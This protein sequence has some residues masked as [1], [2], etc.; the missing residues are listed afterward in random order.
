MSRRRYQ[1]GQLIDGG[2]RWEARWREDVI[3]PLT[4]NTKRVR[5]WDVLATKKECPNKRMAQRLLDEKLREINRDDYKPTTTETFS[6]FSRK[7]ME[8]V[9]VHHKPSTQRS[10]KSV[11]AVHLTPAFEQCPLKEMT[12]EVLQAWVSD[13][14][15]AP[16]TIKN[17]VTTLKTMWGT[18]KAWGYVQHDPFE[19]LRLPTVTKGNT[20]NFTV[21][22]TLAIIDAAKGWKKVFFRILAETGM[23]PGELAGLRIED[24]G[25]RVLKVQQSVWQRQVQTPKTKTAVRKFAISTALAEEIQAHISTAEPN[26]LGLV[27]AA[28]SGRPLS[29]DNFRHR[30]LN[31]I[32][33]K[34]GIRAK[35]EG[36]RCGNYAFRHMNATLMDNLG[37]PLKTRQNRLGHAQIETTL[38]HYTHE[39][40]ADDVAAADQ[41]GALLSPKQDKQA[42]Q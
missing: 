4:G 14:D 9:M 5:K 31:P 1:T 21:D 17:I 35:I 20:Y 13:H 29:M 24:V 12:T 3:D 27:F 41:I 22:E 10:E 26:K 34:L 7:W 2:D 11:I 37:T 19:G 33:D 6:G 28:E 15:A 39:V 36:Q 40:D 16:K 23:R 25:T 8:T 38:A 18:A 32:L 30:T 42:V